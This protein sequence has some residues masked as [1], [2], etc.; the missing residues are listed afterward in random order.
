M[1][2]KKASE[3]RQAVKYEISKLEEELETMQRYMMTITNL[4]KKG[5]T[6]KPEKLNE[7][8]AVWNRNKTRKYIGELSFV[9]VTEC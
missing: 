1:L 7:L 2:R 4:E 3:F 6:V 9:S 5:E 8:I